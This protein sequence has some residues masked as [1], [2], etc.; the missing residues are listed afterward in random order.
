MSSFDDVQAAAIRRKNAAP[1]TKALA[2]QIVQQAE[3]DPRIAY[4]YLDT[5]TSAVN[6][7][8][9]RAGEE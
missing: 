8:L 9:R 5:L 7:E 4:D 3:G 6:A 1:D 2:K